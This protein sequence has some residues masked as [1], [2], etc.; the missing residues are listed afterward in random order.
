MSLDVGSAAVLEPGGEY[1][2]G[3]EVTNAAGSAGGQS[4][5]VKLTEPQREAELRPHCPDT[6]ITTTTITHTRSTAT[7]RF[8]FRA[9]E[10]MTRRF[11]CE[12]IGPRRKR[13]PKPEA[14]FS[15][16]K[17]PKTYKHLVPGTYRFEVRALNSSGADSTPAIKKVKVRPRP[18]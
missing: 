15:T 16:C 18:A 12:L 11:E 13:H 5:H 14:S 2:W 9:T 17:S 6:T 4:Q 3:I 10:T 8:N 7:L 1:A